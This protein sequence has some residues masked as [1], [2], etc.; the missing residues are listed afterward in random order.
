MIYSE[1]KNTDAGGGRWHASWGQDEMVLSSGVSLSRGAG[2]VLRFSLYF[3]YSGASELSWALLR[4]EG[5]GWFKR[6][7]RERLSLLSIAWTVKEWVLC[8]Q[9]CLLSQGTEAIKAMF[10]KQSLEC[11]CLHSWCPAR[12]LLH[13]EFL[14]SL[15][16]KNSLTSNYG[17]LT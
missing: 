13:Q 4:D 2:A 10:Q 9:L 11:Q 14:H 17:L 1:D 8:F 3:S 12:K 5:K 15:I 7:F 16:S 6:W